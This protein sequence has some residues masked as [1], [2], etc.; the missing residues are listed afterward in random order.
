MWFWPFSA[1][2]VEGGHTAGWLEPG[3]SCDYYAF[4][5]WR[6]EDGT[7]YQERML[8]RLN[9]NDSVTDEFQ[10]SRAPETNRFNIYFNGNSVK[11][12]NVQFWTSRRFQ[13]GGEVST[14]QGTSNLFD[15][16]GRALDVAGTHYLLPSPKSTQVNDPP[17][18]GSQPSNS[19]WKWRVRP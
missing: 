2:W 12:A 8:A 6:K 10:I 16:F 13:M 11:S 9:H 19:E 4:A 14:P 7:D 5:A 1:G 17:L 15:M 18:S 3:G